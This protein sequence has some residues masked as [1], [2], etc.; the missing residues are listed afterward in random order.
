MEMNTDEPSDRHLELLAE[1]EK[2]KRVSI[3]LS[4]R[5]FKCKIRHQIPFNVSF[6]WAIPF[7]S[8]SKIVYEGNVLCFG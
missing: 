5:N 4:F 2:R 8:F 1:F 7:P 6:K 3:F